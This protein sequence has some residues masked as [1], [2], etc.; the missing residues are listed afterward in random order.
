MIAPLLLQYFRLPIPIVDVRFRG[1]RS[2][3]I[4]RAYRVILLLLS[5]GGRDGRRCPLHQWRGGPH[6]REHGSVRRS[7]DDGERWIRQFLQRLERDGILQVRRYEFRPR[8]EYFF[9]IVLVP[10][11][12]VVAFVSIVIA[13][14]LLLFLIR[15]AGPLL[16]L[17]LLL[18]VPFGIGPIVIACSPI[19]RPPPRSIALP[20]SIL[21]PRSGRGIDGI[22][23]VIISGCS[24]DDLIRPRRGGRRGYLHRG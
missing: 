23:G 15:V 7:R 11:S 5:G 1:S 20:R 8:F 19:R 4:L 16:L 21:S 12:I 2:D 24:D 14:A 17:L 10:L 22:G 13:C 18:R 6:P 9:G 3:L